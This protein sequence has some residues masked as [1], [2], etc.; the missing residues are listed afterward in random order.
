MN[1]FLSFS[2][3]QMVLAA[4]VAIIL[5]V[6]ML[7]YPGGTLALMAG[8][9]WSI[10]LVLTIFIVIYAVS[11]IVRNAKAGRKW[12]IFVP[13]VLGILAIAFIWLLDVSFIYF[14]AALFFI[15]SGI[16]E[17]VG[18]FY[19]IYGKFFVFLLGVI[20][21]MIGAIII[22]HP[23][24]LPMLIAWYILFWG[25]SRLMLALEIRGMLRRI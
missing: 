17:I 16:S 5:G 25:V 3:R 14:I 21:I 1:G 19:A 18:S 8:T 15:L 9:F 20:N 11:E 6:V 13:I 7:V 2:M 24:I 10:Q 23:M 12:E 22:R 4:A